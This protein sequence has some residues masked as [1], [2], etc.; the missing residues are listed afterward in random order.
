MVSLGTSHWS[1]QSWRRFLVPRHAHH[2]GAA[3]TTL[4]RGSCSNPLDGDWG[5]A[6]SC[7]FKLQVSRV[8]GAEGKYVRLISAGKMLTPDEA[9]VG[10][11]GLKD[12]CFVHCIVTAA[13]PRLRLPS[14]TANE[15]AEEEVRTRSSSGLCFNDGR[16]RAVQS[17]ATH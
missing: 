3:S 13:P 17:G 10:D 14:L 9:I 7:Q 4:A 11:F 15:Q 1:L 2:A 12:N 6:H 16:G 8:I 5:G